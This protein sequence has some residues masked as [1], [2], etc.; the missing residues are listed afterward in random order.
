[1]LTFC[2]SAVTIPLLF[3][4]FGTLNSWAGRFHSMALPPI[5]INS[6]YY[7]LIL[8]LHHDTSISMSPNTTPKLL[9]EDLRDSNVDLDPDN[10]WYDH[11]KASQFLLLY[12]KRTK[13]R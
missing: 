11:L 13:L 12:Q 7:W 10:T 3:P 9:Y 5:T 4:G 2:R 8:H 6:H 1:M